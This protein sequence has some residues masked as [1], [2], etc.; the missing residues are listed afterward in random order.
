[1][2]ADWFTSLEGMQEAGGRLRSDNFI[3]LYFFMILCN[4]VPFERG[5]QITFFNIG[6]F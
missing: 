4:I 5:F 3:N 1:M 2:G 6:V